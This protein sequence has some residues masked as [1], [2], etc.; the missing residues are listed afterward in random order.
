MA[1]AALVPTGSTMRMVT[2]SPCSTRHP[3]E[4]R[5]E[6]GQ[7]G[8]SAD[9]GG[10]GEGELEGGQKAQGLRALAE[11]PGRGLHA[12]DK[13]RR[14]REESEAAGRALLSRR[15]GSHDLRDVRH[16]ENAQA[17]SDK[18]ERAADEDQR[19]RAV[20][21]RDEEKSRGLRRQAGDH[22]AARPQPWRE[23]GS[24]SVTRAG[25]AP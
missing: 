16:L 19:R 12:D 21:A 24:E 22:G 10:R 20:A 4:S 9:G 6:R 7:R 2:S 15:K 11:E 17:K 13:T 5:Q 3:R 23:G 25:A 14:A 1:E 8:E 18:A